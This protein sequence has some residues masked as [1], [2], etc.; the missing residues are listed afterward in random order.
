MICAVHLDGG[1]LFRQSSLLI[2][3]ALLESAGKVLLPLPPL[4]ELPPAAWFRVQSLS[5]PP[6]SCG[7]L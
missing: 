1:K 5:V 3:F 7:G 6:P 2:D 4:D